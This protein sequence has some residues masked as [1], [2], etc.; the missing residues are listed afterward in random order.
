MP[1]NFEAFSPEVWSARVIEKLYQ[2]NV[3]MAIC[4]NTDYEGEVRNQGDTVHVRT[5]GRMTTQSYVRGQTISYEALTPTKETMTVNDAVMFAFE[6]D[7]LDERESDLDPY[8]GY[9]R[10]GAIALDEL[11]DTK[12]FSYVKGSVPTANKVHN[13]SGPAALDIQSAA[14]GATH[15]Y[16]IIIAANKALDV[17][18]AP[19]GGRWMIVT[20]YFRSLLVKDAVY[21]IKG[22]ALGDQVITSG[23]PGMTGG[24]AP[25]YVGQVDGMDIFWSNNLP[26]GASS[27]YYCPF[28][29]GRPISYANVLRKVE[30]LRSETTF[31]DLV[32]GLMLHDGTVFTEHKK[33]LGYAWIDNS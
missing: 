1:N 20:P 7:D 17:Q 30:R 26:T 33:R 6:V 5:Y 23:R 25:N 32:R 16:E 13:S 10:E 24:T 9:V 14:A 2:T 15:P 11:I 21:L 29:Q 28:G 27:T 31:A 8:A 22:S 19:A 4:A 3:A 18:N 12:I